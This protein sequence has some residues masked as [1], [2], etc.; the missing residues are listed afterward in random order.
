MLNDGPLVQV[1]GHVVA[2]RPNEFHPAFKS[3]VV[4][5]GTNETGQEAVV[6]VDDAA[7]MLV[8]HPGGNDLHESR[9]HGQRHAVFVQQG[10]DFLVRLGLRLPF[11]IHMME[12]HVVPPGI[13]PHFW[14]VGNDTSNVA[15][16][17]PASPPLQHI[18]KAVARFGGQQRHTG[19]VGERGNAHVQLQLTLQVGQ[20]MLEVLLRPT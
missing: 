13:F 6:N 18:H 17:L 5:P 9:Q 2:G 3:L 10:I 11:E 4:R 15:R 1:G 14:V 16:Q 19:F 8:D 12:W 20:T 7:L